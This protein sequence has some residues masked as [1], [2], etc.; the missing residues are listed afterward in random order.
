MIWL[1]VYLLE[2]ASMG[3]LMVFH[4]LN[5]KSGTLLPQTDDSL[6]FI[7]VR[8]DEC[9]VFSTS[10]IENNS[11]RDRSIVH[12]RPSVY[13][14]QASSFCYNTNTERRYE[15]VEPYSSSAKASSSNSRSQSLMSKTS[16]FAN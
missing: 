11:L 3:V 5:F 13:D 10:E 16:E 9:H 4:F 1:T 15:Y 8:W 6:D 14:S 7:T 12:T 2:G